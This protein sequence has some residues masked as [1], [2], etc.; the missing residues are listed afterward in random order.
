MPSR[1][2]SKTRNTTLES[3]TLRQR[4]LVLRN[5]PPFV[6][7]IWG[8]HRGL[9]LSMIALRIARSFVPLAVLWVGKLIIDSVVAERGATPDTS[10][11]WRL[12]AIE[13]AIALTGE[14]LTR[15]SSV[16]EGLLGDLFSNRTS[17]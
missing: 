13:I 7:L 14:V 8:T 5:I 9:T 11:I 10:R 16:V 15:I 1:P 17:I 2:A 4:I 6:K 3:P 12:V